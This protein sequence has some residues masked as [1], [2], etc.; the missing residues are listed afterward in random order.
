MMKSKLILICAA[1][2]FA[3]SIAIVFGRLSLLPSSLSLD[4]SLRRL[5]EIPGQYRQ[6]LET[7]HLSHREVHLKIALKNNCG[8]CEHFAKPGRLLIY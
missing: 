1:G 4:S 5:V 7:A 2:F 8:D 6:E 3:V